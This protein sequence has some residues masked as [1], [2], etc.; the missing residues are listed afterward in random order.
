MGDFWPVEMGKESYSSGTGNGISTSIQGCWNWFLLLLGS[1]SCL[2]LRILQKYHAHD[3]GPAIASVWHPLEPST[4]LTCGW[5]GGHKG[6][7]MKN[8]LCVHQ[9]AENPG[10]MLFLA[11]GNMLQP[12]HWPSE[13]TWFIDWN[14]GSGL[15]DYKTTARYCL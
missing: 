9:F 6:V 13:I 10:T 4:V 5:D 12:V 3:K 7:A 15:V 11:H 8:K 2:F 1:C 14:F